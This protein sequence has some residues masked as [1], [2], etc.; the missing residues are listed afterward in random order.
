MHTARRVRAVDVLGSPSRGELQQ[1]AALPA[2]TS[3]DL[4][5]LAPRVSGT[6]GWSWTVRPRASTSP[7]YP[8]AALPRFHQPGC[9][10]GVPSPRDG[11]SPTQRQGRRAVARN[12]GPDAR[13]RKQ[14]DVR[15]SQ[16]CRWWGPGT[17]RWTRRA[18]SP[19][20]DEARKK[21]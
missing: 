7:L 17:G 15:K 1:F 16:G 10:E 18:A 9:R 13:P 21:N 4:A 3:C 8:P 2:R 11:R 14:P 19:P 5:S 20:Q 12:A 6:N